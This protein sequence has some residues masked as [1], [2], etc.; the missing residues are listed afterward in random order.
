VLLQSVLACCLIRG[1]NV[2]VQ[3]VLACCLIRG[4]NVLVQS[5]LVCCLT[6]GCFSISAQ[7]RV[8]PPERGDVCTCCMVLKPHNSVSE[9][10][11][12]FL[13]FVYVPLHL[14]TYM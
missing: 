14:T 3:S 12:H 4:M 13:P 5:V 10:L 6:R 7:L 1:M 8:F 9:L 2:S 11:V